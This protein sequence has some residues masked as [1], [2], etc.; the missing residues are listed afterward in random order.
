MLFSEGSVR[1]LSAEEKAIIERT[2]E[3]T[4]VP[5]AAHIWQEE[6][7]AGQLT[8]SECVRIAFTG[9]QYLFSGKDDAAFAID[10][11]YVVY[12]T[13]DHAAQWKDSLAANSRVYV[14]EQALR[15][16]QPEYAPDGSS[17]TADPVGTRI[18]SVQ[19]EHPL[20]DDE[21]LGFGVRQV[22][23]KISIDGTQ[24]R[25]DFYIDDNL[26]PGQLSVTADASGEKS[27]SMT[28][29]TRREAAGTHDVKVLLRTSDGRGSILSGGSV[30]IPAFF[31]LIND[32]VQKGSLPA[33]QTDVWYKLDAKDRNAYVNFVQETGDISV[34]LYDMYGNRIGTNDL[35]GPR[36]EALRGKLQILPKTDASDPYTSPYQNMF[37]I[38][39][40]KGA[41]EISSDEIRY[42]MIQ[43]KEV[44]VNSDG[45]YL[46]VVSD[47][48]NVPTQI[49]SEPD[50]D[51]ALQKI[52]ECRDL[53][54]N[55][56]SYEMK[57]LTFL[58]INGRIASLAFTQAGSE[59]AISIYPKFDPG[60]DAYGYVAAS[61]LPSLL[62]DISCVEGYAASVRVEQESG[63]GLLSPAA[64]DGTVAVAPSRNIIHIYVT[65][66]D[67]VIHEYR[68]YLL[69]GIDAQGYDTSTLQLFP[70]SYRSGI[71]LLHNQ[72]PTYQFIPYETGI[73]WN[74]LMLAQDHENKSL[75]DDNYHP[76]WVK[77][78]SPVYDGGV[79]RAARSDVVAYFLDPRNFLDQVNIFQFEKLSFDPSI[80]TIDGVRA[81]VKGSF[82]ESTQP[83][84]AASILAAGQEAGV[85]PYFLTSRILQEM[86]RQGQSMLATGTLPGYEGYFNFYNIASNPDPTVENGALINGAKFA[87]WGSD[88][89]E[90]VLTDSEKALLL[91]WTSPDLAIRG[92]AR[93]IASSYID[94]GQNTLYF[95]KFDVVNN[96]DGLYFHQYAQNITM[97]FSEGSRYHSTYRSQSMLHSP[98]SFIIPV[99]TE[100]PAEY[101]NLPQE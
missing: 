46:A 7:S 89:K 51:A 26:R 11:S 15:S 20:Q 97:A 88:P 28:W 84:Y 37:Y 45:K 96:A 58:P 33:G 70:E 82:L 10:L 16:L 60:T 57:D 64:A 12:G 27:F 101:G 42:L 78:G 44:A 76:N 35:P 6:V 2:C 83:D 31:D 47:V 48:G 19:L 23:G 29:D 92:G 86:G 66:F 40:Q 52:V 50:S 91:P 93:W 1:T 53:S 61:A 36:T 4:Q 24:A 99:Y 75:I 9:T 22:S 13:E 59:T 55:V 73:S 34:T 65:D 90:K 100:L 74:D 54:A 41:A 17:T 80:H 21:G 77:D 72:E 98:F 18:Q 3:R 79:W 87:V 25:T 32:G 30:T 95:Q 38:R 62:A 71:W 43:S 56:L 69:S 8:T 68:L 81:M 94:I 14:A 39:V 63:D 85:S 5:G 49:L 67:Q